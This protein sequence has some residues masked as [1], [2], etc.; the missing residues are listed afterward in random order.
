MNRIECPDDLPPAFDSDA[1]G[2]R[3]DDIRDSLADLEPR[4]FI[5]VPV[6]VDQIY[7]AIFFD[8][9]LIPSGCQVDPLHP[10]T[11]VSK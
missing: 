11:E 10:I 2:R 3:A 6:T 7:R 4:R 8:T 1:D 5:H 9:P